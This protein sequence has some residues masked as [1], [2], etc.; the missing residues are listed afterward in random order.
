MRGWTRAVVERGEE[1]WKK[2]HG[3]GRVEKGEKGGGGAGRKQ[4]RERVVWWRVVRA[5]CGNEVTRW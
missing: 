3:I 5:W 4:G 2:R 1:G